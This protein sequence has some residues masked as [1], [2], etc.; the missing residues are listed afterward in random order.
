MTKNYYLIYNDEVLD[1]S[2]DY[3]SLVEKI[4]GLNLHTDFYGE[5]INNRK[6]YDSYYDWHSGLWS[7][8]DSLL[9]ES[10]NRVSVI[11]IEE[12]YVNQYKDTNIPD[13]VNN[14]RKSI[15]LPPLED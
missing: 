12:F 1:M 13:V 11:I 7:S 3:N 15:N 9:D 5:K 10:N 6:M 2:T 4:I 14:Y 8:C